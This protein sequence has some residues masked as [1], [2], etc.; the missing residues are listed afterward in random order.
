[1]LHLQNILTTVKNLDIF[2]LAIT[3]NRY[4]L[5]LRHRYAYIGVLYLLSKPENLELLNNKKLLKYQTF[6]SH[7]GAYDTQ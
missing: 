6:Y 4:R 7:L 2:V 3:S 1:M 5:H